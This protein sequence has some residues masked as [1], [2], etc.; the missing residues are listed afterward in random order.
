MAQNEF[1]TDVAGFYKIILDKKLEDLNLL[2]ISEEMVQMTYKFKEPR[3]KNTFST[4][5]FVALFTTADAQL[6][7]LEKSL[8]LEEAV[9]YFNL[10]TK[11]CTM[12][13]D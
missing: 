7:L 6:A 8:E 9:I 3:V 4:N 13:M 10:Q 12:T 1:V 11:L 5:I 2:F